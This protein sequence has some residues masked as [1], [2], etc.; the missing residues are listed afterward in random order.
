MFESSYMAKLKALLVPHGLVLNYEKDRAAIDT[1][2]H[3]YL[4]GQ[5]SRRVSQVRVWF[6]GKGIQATTMSLASFVSAEQVKV[7]VSCDH[8]RYWFAH[9]DP[10]YLAVYVEAA[11]TFL[12]QDVR[13]LIDV[14]WPGGTLYTDLPDQQQEVTVS[15]PTA[16]HLDP[17]RLDAMLNHRTM[18]IDGPSFRGRPL[19][20]RFDPI[21][22]VLQAPSPATF[23]DLCLR[24][25][26]A[27]DYRPGGQQAV[28]RDLAVLRGVLYQTLA[29]QSPAF[30]EYGYTT[31]GDLRVE[32][33]YQSVQDRSRSSWTASPIGP[34]APTRPI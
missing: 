5:G 15:V 4:Q 18:R 30:A 29:W 6:Q 8:L 2:L 7:K 20:H 27:H 16:S 32:P 22:T 33:P 9:P 13:E 31:P 25:L 17:A 14:Q 24:L 21:R 19:G 26:A 28:T 10:V 34:L 1:G 11:D 12:V 3:L 23:T